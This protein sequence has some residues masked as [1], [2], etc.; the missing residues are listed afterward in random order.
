MQSPPVSYS[1]FR[2]R[3]SDP[4]PTPLIIS[5][6]QRRH[7]KGF[8]SQAAFISVKKWF[9]AVSC[10]QPEYE[11]AADEV[12]HSNQVFHC[13]ISPGLGF[14]SLDETVDPLKDAIVD[15]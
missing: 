9:L 5:T 2:A 12:D 7:W 6:G 15:L 13:T 3:Y 4:V 14:G 10:G 1:A 8:D 11:F